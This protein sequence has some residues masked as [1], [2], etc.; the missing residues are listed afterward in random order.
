MPRLDLRS[1]TDPSLVM[2]HFDAICNLWTF[3]KYS[4]ERDEN[5]D[6][7]ELLTESSQH[8]KWLA[9]NAPW[10]IP[11]VDR[12]VIIILTRNNGL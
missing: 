4:D 12:A 7:K 2:S 6:E 10:M 11:Y 1:Y 5:L 9:D 8:Y 3:A